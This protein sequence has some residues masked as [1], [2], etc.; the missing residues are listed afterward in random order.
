MKKEL[1]SRR[2]FLQKSAL[3]SGMVAFGST[4]I[5]NHADAPP[6]LPREVWIAALSQM[7]LRTDSP[8]AML[9][10]MLNITL[11][12]LA[13]QPDIICL[14]E[15]FAFVN[16]SA[17]LNMKQKLEYSDKALAAF[18]SVA[19]K[20]ECY[21]IC[22]VFTSDANKVF[23]A[24]VV[25]DR[26]GN[27]TG[28]YRKMHL[29]V[30]EIESGLTPGPLDAPVFEADFGKF[31]I[32]I[33][34]DIYYND[35]W[36]KLADKGAEI[37]F[38]PSAFAAGSRVKM[39]ALENQY[40]VVSSTRKNTSMICDIR[41]EVIETTGLWEK[42]LCCAALNLEKVLI[43]S[44]PHVEHF[45]EIMEKY[46]RKIRI[47]TLHEEQFTVIESLDPDIRVKDILKEF[48]IRSYREQVKEAEIAQIKAR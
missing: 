23:N 5:L 19:A 12:S 20:N 34:Y 46:G 35:G 39:K 8:E 30:D 43:D 2:S 4:G 36:Q 11:L 48:G 31:G 40:A 37:V 10:E 26:K 22:P 45:H 24:A 6:K 38:W 17:I 32:Q 33:C 27:K 3:S 1:Y 44:W 47:S 7:D 14:P 9:D 41:G 18:S 42:N 13:F 15:T 29:T 21:V 25:F 16:T 28:E